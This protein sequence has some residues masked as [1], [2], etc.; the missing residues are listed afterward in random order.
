V[1]AA[2]AFR[3]F[4]LIGAAVTSVALLSAAWAADRSPKAEPVTFVDQTAAAG[5]S[6]GIER[7]ASGGDNLIETMG[8]G[9]G[10]VDVDG[11]GRLDVYLVSYSTEPQPGA[12]RP[13]G[14]ALYHNNGDGTFRDVTAQAGVTSSGRGM[15]LAVGDYDNDGRPDLYVTGFGCGRLLHSEG[16]GVFRDVTVA[17]GIRNPG[18]SV[19]AAFFDMDNDGDLDLFVANYLD[20]DPG[21]EIP[22]QM[23]E[24]RPF[25]TIE[26]FRGAPSLLFRNDGNGLFTDVSAT[27]LAG[28]KP[29]KGLGVLAFDFDGDGWMDVFQANDTAPNSLYRNNRDGTFTDVA[30]E[31]NV[32]FDAAGRTL[33]AMGVDADDWD[34]DGRPDVFVANFSR[35][36]N[37]FFVNNGNGTFDDRATAVGLGAVSE[38]MSGFGA[39]FLDYDDDGKVDL[40]VVN[41]HPFEPVEKVWPGITYREPPFLFENTGTGFRDVAAEHGAALSRP[42]AGRGLAVGDYDNDGDPDLLVL[43]VGEPPMLLRNDGGN[44]NA[45]IGVRLRGTRSNRDGVGAKVTVEAGGRRRWKWLPGGTSYAA[46]SD[47]RLLF[48]LGDVHRVDRIEVRWP[49]GVVQT[50]AGLAAN[51]YVTIE[52]RGENAPR[53]GGAR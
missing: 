23:L 41:G 10:F 5:I 42:I 4:T 47:S 38:P 33:G 21:K 28:Q 11:D 26:R 12:G 14:D 16:N 36:R 22:C 35:Q 24:G 52:E 48:G 44:R 18:W 9:G 6:W 39:R 1:R 19:S 3:F 51:R 2:G 34:Q 43:R 27:A 49:S 37:S 45:W 53:A 32:A 13:P 17:A 46:A 31:A 40:F 20:V 15:G 7:L 8:G 50:L 25:C 29:G 30:L